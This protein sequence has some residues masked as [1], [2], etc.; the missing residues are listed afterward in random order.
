MNFIPM[1]QRVL[2]EDIPEKRD[3]I[4]QF[5]A[6]V[7][8]KPTL[9]STVI[10]ISPEIVACKLKI[11]DVIYRSEFV[12]QLIVVDDKQYRNMAYSDV[13]GRLENAD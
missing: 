5:A 7:K 11:G 2:V 1:G 6:N 4:I 10:A 8:E 12:G 3:G 13:L 9:R